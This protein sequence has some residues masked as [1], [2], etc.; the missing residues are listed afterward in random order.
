MQCKRQGHEQF[1]PEPEYKPCEGAVLPY[2]IFV[3]NITNIF[4]EIY[5]LLRGEKLGQK[6]AMWRKNDKYQVCVLP[7]ICTASELEAN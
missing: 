3:T 7:Q 1:Y 4:V 5:A 2:L 6:L